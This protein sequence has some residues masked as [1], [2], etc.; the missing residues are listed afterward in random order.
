MGPEPPISHVTAIARPETGTLATPRRLL[1]L[2]PS[3]TSAANLASRAR[4][5]LSL[6]ERHLDV[7][8]PLNTPYSTDRA[9]RPDDDSSDNNSA[10]SSQAPHSTLL[11]PGPI[12]FDDAVLQAMS[13]YRY[14]Y[15]PSSAARGRCSSAWLLLPT[16]SH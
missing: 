15:A 8:P 4:P 5:R 6:I 14:V 13:H 1:S 7:K 12:E 9:S 2:Y 16:C 11:I 10:M 3:L